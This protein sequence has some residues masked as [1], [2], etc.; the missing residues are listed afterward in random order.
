MK[1]F[2]SY[3]L[4]LLVVSCGKKKIIKIYES[5]NIQKATTQSTQDLENKKWDKI[6]EAAIPSNFGVPFDLKVLTENSSEEELNIASAVAQVVLPG[7]GTGTAF[8]IS[9]DG[10]FI[11]NHHVLPKDACSLENGCGSTYLVRDLRDGGAMAVY[12]NIK[13]LAQSEK[14]DITLGKVNLK[15]GQ[16]IKHFLDISYNE[17]NVDTAALNLKL[18][19]HPF[20]AP[21][22]SSSVELEGITENNRLYSKS[23][24][25]PGNSG[26]PVYDL[27]SKKVIG[28][29]QATR[30]PQITELSMDGTFQVRGMS[31]P[32]QFVHEMLL[33]LFPDYKVGNDLSVEMFTVP[34]LE[35]EM[36]AKYKSI[37]PHY[38]AH[39]KC[40]GHESC[41]MN[42]SELFYQHIGT[43][44]ESAA[45]DRFLKKA[46]FF[47]NPNSLNRY[48]LPLVEFRLHI[49]REYEISDKTTDL[50]SEYYKKMPQLNALKVS[51]DC[52]KNLRSE[53]SSSIS[54]VETLSLMTTLVNLCMSTDLPEVDSSKTSFEFLFTNA[55]FDLTEVN[56]EQLESFSMLA[57]SVLKLTKVSDL[58]EQ[59]LIDID[60]F[61]VNLLNAAKRLS[62]LRVHSSLL[63]SYQLIKAKNKTMFLSN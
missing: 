53:F 31:I 55:N 41:G 5:D 4:L 6:A 49:G 16:K 43:K 18:F 25:L 20:G 57:S 42:S 3:L 50:I 63:A 58:N 51:K 46:G 26:G 10:L 61:Y 27:A 24:F 8:F 9:S 59:N 29:A 30:V 14:L 7:Q 11:T 38:D 32:I 17:E 23:I 21:V 1:R 12:N 56:V 33:K 15:K 36:Y 45:I 19:G 47:L 34:D 48:L 28:V 52:T 37:F 44:D 22:S 35:S 40:K 39:T 54:E 2:L 60:L 62:N 13:V